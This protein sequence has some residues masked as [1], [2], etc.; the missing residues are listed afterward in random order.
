MVDVVELFRLVEHDRQAVDDDAAFHHG[1]AHG[2]DQP[3]SIVGAIARDVDHLAM[4]RDVVVQDVVLSGQKRGRDRGALFAEDGF[5]LQ[6]VGEVVGGFRAVDDGP[7]DG[8]DRVE[9][10]GPLHVHDGDLALGARYQRVD[11]VLV[12]EGLDIAL[13]LDGVFVMVHRL[14]DIDGEHEFEVDADPGALLGGGLLGGDGRGK[15]GHS[16]DGEGGN[17]PQARLDAHHPL[18]SGNQLAGQPRGR[19]AAQHHELTTLPRD[20]AAFG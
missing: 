19:Q 3:A 13:A 9:V 10:P 1:V 17:A 6:A 8:G 18:R 15:A 12:A 4:G 5:L 20:R 14:R 11:H 2:F 7:W 16:G